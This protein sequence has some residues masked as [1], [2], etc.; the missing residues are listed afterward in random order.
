[1]GL[2]ILN[3]SFIYSNL[4]PPNL[5]LKREELSRNQFDTW[6]SLFNLATY[7]AQD[8]GGLKD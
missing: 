8:L 6:K 4:T 5:P 3:I 7:M 1:M 2:S